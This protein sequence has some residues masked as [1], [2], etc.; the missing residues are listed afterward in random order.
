M[1]TSLL[2]VG[3]LVVALLVVGYFLSKGGPPATPSRSEPVASTPVPRG[4]KPLRT[5]PTQTVPGANNV[6]H[7]FRVRTET[8]RQQI[9]AAPRDTVALLALAHLLDDAHQTEDA[10]G[11]YKQYLQ[12]T[13]T[14]PQVWLDLTNAYARLEQWEEAISASRSLLEIHPKHPAA[15]YNLG[16]LYANQGAVEEARTWW[17]QVEAQTEDPALALK[18]KHSLL[19][20]QG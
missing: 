18:A 13:D 16:A 7:T 10:V 9:A 20:L 6:T 19:Q 4:L 11:Y 14:N 2:Y 3:G 1:K 15:M 8:L 5:A 17:R 12:V